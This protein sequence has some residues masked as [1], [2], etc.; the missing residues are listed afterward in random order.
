M[1]VVGKSLIGRNVVSDRGMVIGKLIDLSLETMSGKVTTL[2]V[3]PSKDVNPKLFQLNEQGELII[4][5]TAVKAIKD[6]I[7]ISEGGIPRA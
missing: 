7:I 6:V 3:E 5:F 4:P 1:R 2:I